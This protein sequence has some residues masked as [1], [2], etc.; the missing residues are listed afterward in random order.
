MA[1]HVRCLN[2]LSQNLVTYVIFKYFYYFFSCCKL[3]CL[4]KFKELLIEFHVLY[5]CNASQIAFEMCNVV[6]ISI[7]L[8]RK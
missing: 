6:F 3:P 5:M 1:Y 4:C 7:L 8:L 2:N